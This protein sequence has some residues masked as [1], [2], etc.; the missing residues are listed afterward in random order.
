[1]PDIGT[2]LVDRETSLVGQA[3]ACRSVSLLPSPILPVIACE[4]ASPRSALYR[5]RL[6]CMTRYICAFPAPFRY[7]MALLH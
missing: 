3:D 7:E 5:G 1:M 2:R 4:T 6:V